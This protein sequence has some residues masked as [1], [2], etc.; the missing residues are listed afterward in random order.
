MEHHADK[1][2]LSASIQVHVTLGKEDLTV[3]VSA[4]FLGF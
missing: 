2:V 1:G 3:K 4:V